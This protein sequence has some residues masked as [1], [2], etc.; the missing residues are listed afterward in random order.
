VSAFIAFS[1]AFQGAVCRCRGA[2]AL[3]A[4]RVLVLLPVDASRPVPAALLKGMQAGVAI[5]YPGPVEISAESIGALPPEPADFQARVT[6]WIAYKYGRQQFD[7]IVAAR[8]E[9]SMIATALR[10]RCWP[11]APILTILLD[12]DLGSN[13]QP[14]PRSTSVEVAMDNNATLRSAL[15][16]LPNTRHVALLGGS[17]LLDNS[18]DQ[19]IKQI[20]GK[21]DPTL[22]I[23]DL[24]N[25]TLE[26]DKARTSSLPAQ[27]VIL[28]GSY[29]H[30]R[31]GRSISVPGVIEYVAPTANAPMFQDSDPPIGKGSV[32]GA[33]IS[34]PTASI[35]I[36]KT[37]ALLL[38]G[39]DPSSVVATKI[40]T[41]FIVDWRQIKRWGISPQT[42][43]P[44]ATVLYRDPS[45]WALYRRYVLGAVSLLVVLFSMIT[46]L[47]LERQRRLKEEKLNSAML[48]SLPGL[49]LLVSS[50]GEILRTSQNFVPFAGSAPLPPLT[51]MPRPRYEDY[52]RSL[53]GAQTELQ[54][55]SAIEEVTSG[56]R[57]DATVEMLLPD[58]QQWLEIRVIALPEPKGGSLIVHLDI[59]ERKLAE[60]EQNRSRENIH[61]LN[62]VAAIGQLAGSLAHELSQ[63]LAAIL[64]NAQA[65]QRF[66][67][68][69]E[70]D[71]REIKEALE[72]ITRDDRRARSIIQE[73]RSL[74]RK[75][76]VNLHPVDLNATVLSLIK[77]L[78]SETQ[79][80]EVSVE[81]DL[82]RGDLIVMGDSGPLQQVLLNLLQ[83]GM[84]AMQ[85][86]PP[87]RRR[88]VV[89][90][91]SNLHLQ[92]ASIYVGD[93]GP[94]VADE[95]RAKLFQP[96][97]TTKKDGLGLGLSICH[98]IIA[99]FGGQ[100]DL[101]NGPAR[102]AMFAVTLPLLT[103]ALAASVSSSIAIA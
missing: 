60:Q 23:I 19:T 82:T 24:T 66:A 102:G 4:K 49:A 21:I 2:E 41:S 3:P 94:G 42:F 55:T 72:D 1:F 48:E 74:M 79:R 65:A 47:L 71:L 91:G 5:A 84:D 8:P 70:P 63:P 44:N 90:T 67:D 14:V 43:P 46:F 51:G 50:N 22:E 68:R 77:I 100:I 25:L 89:R 88:L 45:V 15:K 75:E 95:I 103:P 78:K 73:M 20:I 32:G 54:P 40:D 69:P 62:R 13:P 58:Q 85:H 59:T 92:T 39:A 26:E 38:K 86:L 64:S 17:S 6:D 52:L 11:G 29:T 61:H 53:T 57:V 96:F 87:F 30:D 83:N 12:D 18:V 16:M 76:A 56:R 9:P 99:S 28:V 36:G 27:T 93:S 37:L 34:L 31:N 97:V 7:V 33:V 80:A 98:S 101:Q 35:A 10:D 81:L